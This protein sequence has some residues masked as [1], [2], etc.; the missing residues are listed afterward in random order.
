MPA[1]RARGDVLV[2]LKVTNM[3]LATAI[4]WI[5]RAGIED[6]EWVPNEA[7]DG[8]VIRLPGG[9]ADAEPK[10]E[11]GA[12]PRRAKPDDEVF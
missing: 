8:I 9:K 3:K 10:P 12:R 7:G 5:V 2:T 1:L 6:A 4:S 11:P